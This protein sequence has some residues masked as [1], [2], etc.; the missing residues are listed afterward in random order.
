MTTGAVFLFGPFLLKYIK[1]LQGQNPEQAKI[2]IFHWLPAIV[3]IAAGSYFAFISESEKI[4]VFQ[5]L[6]TGNNLY[7][8]IINCVSLIHV[9]TYLILAKTEIKK[10]TAVVGMS[11]SQYEIMNIDWMNFFVNA[12]GWQT[13]VLFLSYLIIEVFFQKYAFYADLVASPTIALFFYGNVFYRG[14][15]Y[16]YIFDQKKFQELLN[17]NIN[18]QKNIEEIATLP[19]TIS[20]EQAIKL[21]QIAAKLKIAIEI[22]KVYTN[23]EISLQKL[24]DEL[25]CGRTTLSQ[26]INAHFKTT[27]YDIINKNRVE[28]VQRLLLN[29]K[30]KNLKIDAIGEMAGFYSRAT[31]YSVF[32]KYTGKTPLDYKKTI[33]LNL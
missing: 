5:E 23:P 27:F 7:A 26:V 33:P 29:E 31:F 32:K 14:F 15:M 1:L 19:K 8:N 11:Y 2:S 9:I 21:E 22:Q 18:I 28:E 16:N 13:M 12:L 6:K 20:E 17:R 3:F 4:R 25:E 24:A 10:F 30:N